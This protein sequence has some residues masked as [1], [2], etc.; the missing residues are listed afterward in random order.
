[1][2]HRA[3]K[4]SDPLAERWK[5]LPSQLRDSI[6]QDSTTFPWFILWCC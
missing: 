6:I 4:G 2:N 3:G 5:Y 1:M